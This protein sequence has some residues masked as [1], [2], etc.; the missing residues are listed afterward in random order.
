[1]KE[2]ELTEI[3]DE[4]YEK[5]VYVYKLDDSALYLARIVADA[6]EDRGEARE[7]MKRD[8]ITV[9]GQNLAIKSHPA[10]DIIKVCNMQ[11][12]Q[13]L[14]QLGLQNHV[15]EDGVLKDFE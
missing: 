9:K 13:A 7:V 10:N 3:A 8:G 11:I 14:K 15:Q 1:M 4:I 6:W 2:R 12:M 5:L